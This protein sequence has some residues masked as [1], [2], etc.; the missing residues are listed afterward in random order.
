MNS[1]DPTQRKLKPLPPDYNG[2]PWSVQL[3]KSLP[4]DELRKVIRIYGASAVN[5]AMARSRRG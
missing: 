1:V 4:N 3:L 5:A 2:V